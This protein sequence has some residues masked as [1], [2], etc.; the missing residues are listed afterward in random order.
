M[1]Q[2]NNVD[3]IDEDE[4]RAALK[5]LRPDIA[6]FRS[7]VHR[8][9]EIASNRLSEAQRQS[10]NYNSNP[11]QS[12]WLRI[13]A[14]FAPIHL[15][16]RGVDSN[17]PPISFA[18][19]S[20][21]KKLVI[22]FAFPFLCFFMIGLTAIGM[23][24]IRAAQKGQI[25][26]DIDT[27]QARQ[28]TSQWWMMYGWIAVVV[29]ITTLV[30]PFLGWTTPLMIALV[31]SGFAAVSFVRA[32]AK[33]NLVE[34]SLIGGMCVACL[35]LLGQLSQT[36]ST[37][38][39]QVLDPNLVTGVLFAGAFMIASF[40]RPL[41][42]D[43]PTDKYGL[44]KWTRVGLIAFLM[45][46]V[47]GLAYLAYALESYLLLIGIAIVVS[48]IA[49]VFTNQRF[50]PSITR[51]PIVGGLLISGLIMAVSTQSY[52]RGV[53]VSSIRPYVESF[54]GSQ[55]GLWDD[56]ADAAK[57]LDETG[58]KFNKQLVAQHFQQE[59]DR[60]PQTRDWMLTAAVRSSFLS[61]AEMGSYSD[62]TADRKRLVDQ[63]YIE[64]PIVNLKGDYYRIAA[65]AVDQDL[66]AADKDVLTHR[67]MVNWNQLGSSDF[68]YDRLKSALLVTELF[69]RLDRNVQLKQRTADV[70]RWLL[71]SQITEPSPFRSGGGFF[72]TQQAPDS[73]RRATLAAISL[74]ETYGVPPALD[75][76]QLRS[77]LRPNFLYDITAYDYVPKMIARD[78]LDHLSDAPPLKALDYLQ[79][80]LPLWL[81]ILLVLLLGYA[82]I[83]SPVRRSN[84]QHKNTN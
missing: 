2:L 41:A 20:L 83:S 59:L 47:F 82:T 46:N 4:I 72:I 43:R 55:L 42:W 70:H 68:D 31:C 21:G 10:A 58:E 37:H 9:L 16:S 60:N 71:S 84:A 66:S 48:A 81:S 19:V 78:K 50:R 63:Q 80:D 6:S 77:Y 38:S 18:A 64:Q 79:T 76:M 22:V 7:G 30:A 75:L 23:L 56:W 24:R 69:N 62:I 44:G 49:V 32:L 54:D 52:W 12:D 29:F 36:F 74:M 65:I 67:L 25:A 53:T 51:L 15:L 73:D 8:R 28:A 14:S 35:G 40:V 11:R 1:N 27:E 33:E 61:G 45:I 5:T 3:L 39:T 57:W 34:R 13:A 26:S 17:I